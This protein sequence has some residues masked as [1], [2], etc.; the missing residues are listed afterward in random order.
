M[1]RLMLV[2]AVVAAG[3][4]FA[5]GRLENADGGGV[6]TPPASASQVPPQF[7][8]ILASQP[9][10]MSILSQRGALPGLG[11]IRRLAGRATGEMQSQPAPFADVGS[12]EDVRAVRNDIRRDIRALNRLSD[13]DGSSIVEVEHTLSEVYSER[14]LSSLGEQGQREFAARV[15]GRTQAAQRIRVL[16]FQGV[17][18]AGD[19][20]LAQVVY[21]LSTRAPSGRFVARAPAIWTVTLAR[22]D[23]RWRFVRGIES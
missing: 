8:S 19:R 3:V 15:A 11:V 18:V 20:A 21:R 5:K 17:F 12:R 4:V 13:N 1:V 2:V 23:G 9:D 6:G 16:D 10:A 14:V 22:E 7:R